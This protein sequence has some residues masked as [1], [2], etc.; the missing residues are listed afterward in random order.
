VETAGS[1]H[2]ARYR[3]ALLPLL[4]LGGCLAHAK[5]SEDK[6]L[7]DAHNQLRKKQCAPPLRWSPKLAASAEKWAA[8]LRKRGCML[9]H[10]GGEY[11][12]NLAAGTRGTLGPERV[13]AMWYDE[14]KH[15]N[16]KSGGFSMKTGHFTQVV[17]QQTSQ[18]G[19]AKASCDGLELW[20]CQYDPPGNVQGQYRENV[21]C[22]Q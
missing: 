3:R 8:T 16:F 17:W 7:L 18:L 9:Q 1:R 10:S 20:V 6:A 19:C 4:I 11:G 15:Y 12:E 13:V 2:A 5:P 21:G 14:V 22:R